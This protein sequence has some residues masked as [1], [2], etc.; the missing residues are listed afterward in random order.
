MR[1]HPTNPKQQMGGH[2]AFRTPPAEQWEL[3]R[4]LL[5]EPRRVSEP[6]KLAVSV[7]SCSCHF[8]FAVG[9][10]L[11]IVMEHIATVLLFCV[12]HGGGSSWLGQGT[13]GPDVL[14]MTGKM[15]RPLVLKMLADIIL[16]A[17]T[18]GGCM[19]YGVVQLPARLSNFLSSDMYVQSFTIASGPSLKSH[20]FQPK[21]AWT[22]LRCTTIMRS[23][24]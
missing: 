11:C 1:E 15:I 9:V 18:P 20:I 6:L 22:S 8:A 24:C 23:G 4:E 13:D 3:P 14:T 12:W 21:P 2:P 5:G 19:L 10:V 17:P 16:L 7:V